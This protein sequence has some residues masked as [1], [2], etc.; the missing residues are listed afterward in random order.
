MLFRMFFVS[1]NDVEK[2]F[3]LSGDISDVLLM[4]QDATFTGCWQV[5]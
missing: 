5:F 3:A 4:A 1:K 2:P